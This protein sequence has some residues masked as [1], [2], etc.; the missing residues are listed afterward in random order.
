MIPR[1]TTT[2]EQRYL[3]S[4]GTQP[5]PRRQDHLQSH[6]IT[7]TP[8]APP[9][10]QS[11]T[12]LT[13]N[14]APF[15]I[16]SVFLRQAAICLY[17][18]HQTLNPGQ[19]RASSYKETSTQGMRAW[20]H[21]H[22]THTHSGDG[23]ANRDAGKKTSC[24]AP[25]TQSLSRSRWSYRAGRVVDSGSRGDQSTKIQLGAF[26]TPRAMSSSIWCPLEVREM[27]GMVLPK[28]GRL[29]YVGWD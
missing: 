8:R 28:E 17:R 16:A 7:S 13:A 2:L 23:G 21:T 24:L 5:S 6:G 22:K 4:P 27:E 19:S 12:L 10:V 15:T 29:T 25:G 11:S 9:A 18:E 20:G 3:S 14:P 26:D 1:L